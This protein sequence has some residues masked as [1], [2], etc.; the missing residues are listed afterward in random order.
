MVSIRPA[1]E[2][3]CWCAFLFR[4]CL[5]N[6]ILEF[7]CTFCFIYTCKILWISQTRKWYIPI[8]D[9][10]PIYV[11]LK[12]IHTAMLSQCFILFR[13]IPRPFFRSSKIIPINIG[14]L[15][16]PLPLACLIVTLVILPPFICISFSSI[17][18]LSLPP[19]FRVVD[20][21]FL[22]PP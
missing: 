22:F 20:R 5:L 12:I 3:G 18:P 8:D 17:C 1:L 9:L 21:S 16:F 11:R 19:C 4:Y 6:I 14:T 13:M 15:L 2:T 10:V 7:I